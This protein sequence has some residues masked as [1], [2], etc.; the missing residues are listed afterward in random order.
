MEI[1]IQDIKNALSK[2]LDPDLKKDLITLK[3]IENISIKDS[4]VSFDLVLT[5]PACPLKAEIKSA[6]ETAVKSIDNKLNV[7]VNVTSRV[8]QSKIVRGEN[9]SK[10]KNILAVMSGKGGVGKS[11]IAVNL[12]ISLAKLGAKVGLI[13]ADIYGPSIPM[14]FDIENEHPKAIQ[15]GDKTYITPIEKYGVK[16]ISSGFFID[17]SKAL[18]WRGPMASSALKQLFNDTDWGELDYLICDM[19]PGTGD[20]HLTLIQD[21]KITASIIVG[22]PNKVAIADVRKAISMLQNENLATPIIG[23]VENMAYFTPKELP[24]NKYYIFG[25][26]G[27]ENLAKELNIPLISQIPLIQSIAEAGESGHPIEMLNESEIIS[28]IFIDL[29]KKTAQSLSIINTNNQ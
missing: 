24:N 23:I 9:L 15:K 29:A 20:I 4:E 28:D 22:T 11:T 25:K 18:I 16:V 13:D 10:V 3:M 7:H 26:S 14:M 8:I 27:C 12:A 21:L 1:E 19:P 6:C 2:V 17:P 5:T